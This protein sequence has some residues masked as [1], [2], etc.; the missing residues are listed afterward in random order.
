MTVVADIQK[1]EPGAKIILYHLNA[2]AQGAG[3]FFFH[4]HAQSGSIFWQGQQYDPFP[5]LAEGFGISTNQQMQPKLT[6][7]NING[8]ITSLCLAYDDLVGAIL[9]VRSTFVQYLDDANFDAPNP[10]AD[11]TQKF[12]DEIWYVE[13]K[14]REDNVSIEFELASALDFAGARLPRRQIIANKCLWLTIGGYRGPYCGYAGPPVAMYD[15]TPTAS[16]SLDKCGGRVTSCKMRFGD[17]NP[18]PY[19]GFPA[20]GLLR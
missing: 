3:E 11:P 4:N 10:T 16:P 2:I 15:D 5:I 7:S 19:G 20:A 14:V 18:L 6:V 1:L 12:P 8:S 9:T 17:D 13:R